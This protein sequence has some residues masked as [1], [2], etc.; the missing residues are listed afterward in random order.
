MDGENS[1]TEDVPM[2]RR[3][4]LLWIIYCI[5]LVA[6]PA[7][8]FIQQIVGKKY[9]G[10]MLT[11]FNILVYAVCWV[12]VIAMKTTVKRKIIYC[13]LALI[14]VQVIAAFGLFVYTLIYGL[15]AVYEGGTGF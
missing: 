15:D 1:F 3:T 10:W 5:G 2:D 13:I 12:S 14:G 4:K 9:P 6:I 8:F 7:S 11:P